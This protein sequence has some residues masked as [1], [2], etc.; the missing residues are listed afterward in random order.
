MEERPF[1]QR[2]LFLFLAVLVSRGDVISGRFLRRVDGPNIEEPKHDRGDHRVL[3][4]FRLVLLRGVPGKQG[5]SQPDQHHGQAA[6]VQKSQDAE[7][8]EQAERNL[9]VD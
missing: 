2:G 4:F 1:A 8:Q 6:V 5:N 9:P 3:R 7:E